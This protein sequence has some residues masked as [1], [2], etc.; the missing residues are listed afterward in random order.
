MGTNFY[1]IKRK[2][3]LYNTPLHIGKSSSGWMFLF[4]GYQDYH[5]N[6]KFYY[7][8]AININSIED[9]VKYLNND[10]I[11]I[12]NEY[13]EEY[14]LEEF[15]FLVNAKQ[16]REKDNPDNFSNCANVGGYRFSYRDF[17]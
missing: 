4:H 3:S 12:L 10:D 5:F 8:E 13:D 9:W 11:V 2:P 7:D 6:N 14:P 1:A 17:K 16:E 15:L